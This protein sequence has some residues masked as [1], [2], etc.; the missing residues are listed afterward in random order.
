MQEAA[1]ASRNGRIKRRDWNYYD[2]AQRRGLRELQ[3]RSLERGP[4]PAG[5][6]VGEDR[7]AGWG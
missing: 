3:L 2:L 4:W 1:D 5:A 6:G 7:R